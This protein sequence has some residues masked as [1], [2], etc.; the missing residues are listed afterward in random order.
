MGREAGGQG[1]G[2][3]EGAAAGRF[4]LSVV[5][6]AYNE[7]NNLPFLLEALTAW[8][9]RSPCLSTWEVLVVDDGSADGTALVAEQ[10]AARDARVRV[11][12]HA[13]NLGMGAAIRTG[14][15]AATC[16]F[17]TQLPADL[18]VPPETL[19]LFLPHLPGHDLVLS[20]YSDR[21]D[22]RLRRL[23]ASGY[24]VTARLIL[25]R[26]ADYTGTMV[27]RRALLSGIDIAS[28]SF[29]ANLELP[30]KV[31][32]QGAR[33][34]VVTFVPAPRLSGRSKVVGLRRIA[35]V[36]R[37]LVRLRRKVRGRQGE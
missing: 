13:R 21:G 9:A 37:E 5:I 32:R 30:L 23:L 17:V 14:Y 26:R 10:W 1:E 15:Q 12:R 19:D 34:T 36:L 33:H 24:R 35:F 11:L 3:R 27:F 29:V 22:T 20:V 18:Q 2:G 28:D 16:D 25:G 6:M 4:S 8:L 31:L 7:Q